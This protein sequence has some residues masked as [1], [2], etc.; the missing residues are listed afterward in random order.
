MQLWPPEAHCDL[1]IEINAPKYSERTENPDQMGY[2]N[3]L[4]IKRVS[5]SDFFLRCPR[6]NR[7]NCTYAHEP[8][9]FKHLAS[10]APP[11]PD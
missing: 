3:L 2:Q 7:K 1:K 10:K 8:Q 6:L 5:K 9:F 4:N 11:D